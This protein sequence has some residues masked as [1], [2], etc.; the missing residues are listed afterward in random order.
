VFSQRYT[1][2][3]LHLRLV[4]GLLLF[5]L[6]A[7]V[8]SIAQSP[9]SSG[10]RVAVSG[11]IQPQYEFT[12]ADGETRDR[13]F[14]R[15]LFVTLDAVTGDDWSAEVQVDLGRVASG[16]DRIVIKNAYVQYSGWRERGITF[17]LGN[18]K[19]PFSRSLIASSSRRSFVERPFSGDR[20]FGSPGRLIGIKADGWHRARTIYWSGMAGVTRN[21]PDPDEI[22]LDGASEGGAGWSEGPIVVAR[23]ELHPLG[24]LPRDHSDFTR[25]PLR[26]A[27]GAAAYRWWNDEDVESH[28]AGTVDASRVSALEVSG[29]LRGSGLSIEAEFEHVSGETLD[30][31]ISRG[32]Y[33]D[34]H[35]SLNKVSAESGYMLMRERLEILGGADVLSAEAFDH[36]WRRLSGGMNVYVNRHALK[37]SLMHRE[38]F[39]EDGR[40][41]ARSRATYIQTQ[42]AF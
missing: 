3:V 35:L 17:T 4:F 2:F 31:H 12:T 32:L 1:R 37:L 18:Q 16:A 23:V 42:F 8:R 39:N 22:R 27:I 21:S 5:V 6:A 15:R 29:G 34:G 38:S 36:P 26:F 7:P 9:P 30:A 41:G 25:G 24:E 40:D 13:A 33:R 28:G 11:Y 20:G 19:P 10:T 14:F